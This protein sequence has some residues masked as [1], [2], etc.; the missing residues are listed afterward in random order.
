MAISE[1]PESV[2]K[3]TMATVPPMTAMAP[4]PMPISAT[5][6]SISLR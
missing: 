6:R 4:V 5:R 1:P 2:T 3:P